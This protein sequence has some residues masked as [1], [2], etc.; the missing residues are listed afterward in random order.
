MSFEALPNTKPVSIC[1]HTDGCRWPIGEHPTFYC[2]ARPDAKTPYC[3][4]HNKMSYT[5]RVTT[6]G[7][8]RAPIY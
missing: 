4:A 7:K 6:K 3:T 1:D 8:S 5:P 2:N